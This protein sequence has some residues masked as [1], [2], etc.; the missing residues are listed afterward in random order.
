MIG[1][2]TIAAIFGE[3]ALNSI[4]EG[5]LIA[6]IA[7]LGLRVSG[8][9]SSGTKFAVWLV[10]LL[11]IVALPL[12]PLL[13]AHTVTAHK[14]AARV[15]LPSSWADAI[16]VCWAIIATFSGIRLALGLW[17]VSRLR[18]TCAP[19]D[20]GSFPAVQ[21][22][23][24]EFRKTRPVEICS[25][26]LVRVPTAIGFFRPAIVVPEWALEL[27]EEELKAVVLHELAHLR[28]RDDWTNLA[29]KLLRAVFFFHPAVW[30]IEKRLSMEREMA[31][32]ELVLAATGN[33][34]AY[35]ECLVSLAEKSL[36]Q[37]GLAMAQA[38]IGRARETVQRLERILDSAQPMK[39]GVFK[40]ALLVASAVAVISL[41][42]L[43]GAPRLIAF[44]PVDAKQVPSANVKAQIVEPASVGRAVQVASRGPNHLVNP[45]AVPARA[46]SG[47]PHRNIVNSIGVVQADAKQVRPSPGLVRTA[48]VRPAPGQRMFVVVETTQFTGTGTDLSTVRFCVWR[49]TF[50]G[51]EGRTVH[52]EIIAKSI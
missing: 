32:D 14:L 28:R 46:R 3:R 44:R 30:W 20:C 37:R 26:L 24:E 11:A 52:T 29:Q 50:D 42:I 27:A 18:A 4:P 1:L 10:T 47:D 23:V 35:A 16:F 2:E 39:S 38:A 15:T 21:A 9:Q 33:R 41:G 17:K 8:K 40:P 31:C 45:K 13:G 51:P 5:L 25:S 49:V 34:Q 22:E 7:W 43:A 19:F 6:T 48:A 12:V 36:F